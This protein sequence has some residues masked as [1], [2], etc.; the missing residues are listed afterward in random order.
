M[1]NPNQSRYPG[2]MKS[3]KCYA[4]FWIS[5]FSTTGL[6]TFSDR[7]T[8]SIGSSKFQREVPQTR[9]QNFWHTPMSHRIVQSQTTTYWSAAWVL[10]VCRL[11]MTIHYF[12]SAADD[13]PNGNVHSRMGEPTYHTHPTPNN[14]RESKIQGANRVRHTYTAKKMYILQNGAYQLNGWLFLKTCRDK[15]VGPCHGASSGVKI[16]G[17]RQ[18]ATTLAC[19][20]GGPNWT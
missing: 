5:K 7:S 6:P 13:F 15:K 2:Y 1:G 18:K 20:R 10:H 14:Y 16:L 9:A 12:A 17:P 4:N 8:T 19:T 3:V 11:S